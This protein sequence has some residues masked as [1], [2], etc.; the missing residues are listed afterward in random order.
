MG[1]IIHEVE[2]RCGRRV[3]EEGE[4]G[5]EG[6]WREEILNGREVR[7]GEAYGGCGSKKVKKEEIS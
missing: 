5:R 1:I 7:Y 3:L 2:T 4:L 6:G